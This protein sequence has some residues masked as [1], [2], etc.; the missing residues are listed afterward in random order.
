M[1]SE[2]Y[3]NVIKNNR[4]KVPSV[5]QMEAV[6]CGAASLAMI[7]EYHRLFIPLEKLRAECGVSRDGSKAG[8]LIKTA[9]A[10]GFEAKGYRME[11]EEAMQCTMPAIIHWNFN[12]FVVLEGVDKGKVYL[13][14][15]AAG[16]RQ[17]SMEEF[18]KS[19]TGI[20]LLFEETDAFQPEGNKP[21]FFRTSLELMKGSEVPITFLILVG[22]ALVFPAL[23]VPIF[24]KVFLDDILLNNR[25]SWLPYLLLGML[26][27]ALVNTGLTYLREYYLI[28]LRIKLTTASSG[29]FVWHVLKLPA[30]FFT[31]R[32]AGDIASRIAQN[33]N[34]AEFISSD[35]AQIALNVLMVLCYFVLMFLY[36]PYL[37]MIGLLAAIINIVYVKI[38][39]ERQKVNQQA[40]LNDTQKMAGLTMNGISSIETLKASGNENDFFSKWAGYQ[41]KTVSCEQRNETANRIMM[42]VPQFVSTMANGL[43]LIVGAWMIMRGDM[44][45]GSL[46]AF[47]MLLM[48]FLGPFQQ[49]I[50]IAP[51]IQMMEAAVNSLNDVNN[52]NEDGGLIEE[53]DKIFPIC[54]AK[55]G[56]E[57]EIRDLTFGYNKTSPPLIENFNLHIKPGKRVA[58]VGTSGSGKSTIARLIAGLFQPWSGNI[59]LDGKMKTDIPRRIIANSMAIVDQEIICFTGSV[60]DNITL[61]DTTISDE[62]VVAAARSA[63]IHETIA[64]RANGYDSVVTEAGGNLSGGQRQRLEIARALAISP[65]ILIMD[66]ATS[67]LDSVTEMQVDAEI[68]KL[69]CTCIIVAHRLSTIRDCD[70]IIVLQEGRVVER[71][72]HDYLKELDG[73]Y[74]ELIRD[75]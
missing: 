59:L 58:L 52:Y 21:S 17:V 74:A 2:K 53:A 51:R 50:S 4:V 57:I 25:V 62:S 34:V 47:Q 54:D 42:S 60:R 65:A 41:A 73:Y 38:V 66:E 13:N 19:F 43:I 14:D 44:T 45:V 7:F 69:G 6:E 18:D 71:G 56:G 46:V 37:T 31:Q 8:N 68:R 63:C 36:D 30:E 27:V 39:H 12:H 3:Q 67:A 35:V 22:V 26:L 1:H 70:E 9:R 16:P 24:T 49:L 72:K 55:L 11:P 28:R 20:I 32:F 40:I 75:M 23:V 10:H 33:F 61:W 5:L 15:P 29:K 64:S 48:S